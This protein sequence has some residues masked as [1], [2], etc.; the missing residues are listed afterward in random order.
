MASISSLG[1]GSG[2]DTAA[3]LEQIKAAEQTRLNPYTTLQ[4]SYKAKI[5]SWGQISNSLSTLQKKT[6]GLTENAFNTLTVS[7]NTAFTAKADS[8][9]QADL[10]SVKVNQLATMHKLSTA[11]QDDQ[12]AQLGNESSGTRTIVIAQKD[13]SEMRVELADDETSLDQMVKAINRQKGDVTASL[14]RTDDGYQ[15]VLSSRI[16]GSEGEMSVTVEGDDELAKVLNTSNGGTGNDAMKEVS[17]ALDA[18]L[19]VNGSEFTRSSNT[20]TDIIDGVTLT[21]NEVSKDNE[22]EQLTLTKDNSAIKSSVQ[23]FVTQYN[24][25]MGIISNASKYVPY[26]A[27]SLSSTDVATTNS[28]NGALMGDSTLRGLTSELR[29]TVNGNYGITSSA[30]T[31]LAALGIT[32]DA[33]TGQMTLSEDKLDKAIADSPEDIDALFNGKGDMPGLA[34]TL[35]E[36]LTK[37]LGDEDND[38]EGIIENSTDTL[39]KQV[40]QMQTQIDRTQALIDASVERY[41]VQFQQLDS[42]MSQL[43]SMSSQ[44]VSLL[45]SL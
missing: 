11:A 10:H 36:I 5:S 39:D 37:Y 19:T 13:G 3:M 43:N 32:I 45:E 40:E 35:D 9:A 7:T 2:L 41:R 27:S 12:Y 30:Y 17:A 44:L 28:Q 1:I 34:T 26:D 4:K 31:S 8:T 33:S 18:K 15:M 20:I 22:A 21:L 38:I 16:S 14:Q 25:L 24:S 6:K 29:A 42:T 23:E